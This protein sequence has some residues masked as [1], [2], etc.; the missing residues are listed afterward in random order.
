MNNLIFFFQEAIIGIRRSALMSFISIATISLSL[1]VFGIFLLFTINI[2]KLS[3]MLHSKLEVRV[4]LEK[5]VTKTDIKKIKNKIKSLNHI[6]SITYVSK[7]AA[8]RT[9]QNK[10]PHLNIGKWMKK[11]PLPDSFSVQIDKGVSVANAAKTIQTIP[12]VKEATYLGD[13]AEKVH[14]ITRALRIFGIV[15]VSLLTFATLLTIVN[16]IHLTVIARKKEI[17]IMQL[18]GATDWFIRWPFLIEGFLF[19][20]LGSLISVVILKQ[21]TYF[22]GVRLMNKLPFFPFV[23]EGKLVTMMIWSILMIGATMGVLGALV[24]VSRSIKRNV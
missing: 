14:S 10:F 5:S 12:K 8:W 7:E 22:L 1:I 20:V 21:V 17:T 3:N 11:N 6:N 19:G 9:I 18:V 13:I 16:T 15:L 2:H 4:Y 23:F 24:S